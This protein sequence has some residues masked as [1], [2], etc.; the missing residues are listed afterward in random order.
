VIQHPDGSLEAVSPERAKE[1]LAEM[2]PERRAMYE[3]A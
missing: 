3:K 2:P 1:H